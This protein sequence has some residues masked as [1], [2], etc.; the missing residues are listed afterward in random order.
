MADWKTHISYG[1][2]PAYLAYAYGHMFQPGQNAGNQGE[3]E[4]TDLSSNNV[5]VTQNYYTTTAE[6]Q[7]G[8]PPRTPEHQ[9]SNGHYHY[10]SAGVLYID[11]TQ[12]SRFLLA[13]SRQPVYDERALETKRAGSDSTSDSETYI[14]P[15]SW[16]STSSR[17]EILLQTDPTASIE[18]DLDKETSNK[19]PVAS[20]DVSSSLTEERG[21]SCASGIQTTLISPKNPGVKAKARTAFSESQMNILVHKFS[22]QRYLPPSEMKNLAEVT[23]LTYKQVKTWF[24]NRRMKLRRHQ[25]DSSWISERYAINNGAPVNGTVYNIPPYSPSYQGEGRPQHMVDTA[26][27]NTAPQNV[28]LYM[29]T[30]GP[31]SAGYPSW[32]SVPQ[33]TAV[34]IRTQ[35]RDWPTNPNTGH[36]EYNPHVFNVGFSS[37]QCTSL[38][39][40]NGESVDNSS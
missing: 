19:S 15:D 13:G 23:G 10:Q 18:K 27:K 9:V 32:T 5:G 1:Y 29:A 26:F 40:K 7:E 17:E 35:H 6:T 24:Q 21:K 25:K 30:V 8:S 2:N 28:A 34:P 14:S 12:T 11:A 20:E 31:G 16:S 36:Y 38:E 3:P 39:S 37:G 22:I 4:V 33:Q